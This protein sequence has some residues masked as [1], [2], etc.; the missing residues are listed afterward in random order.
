MSDAHDISVQ[1]QIPPM[2]VNKT[3]E[4]LVIELGLGRADELGFNNIAVLIDDECNLG[5]TGNS[6][7]GGQSGA[8]TKGK[9]RGSKKLK[10]GQQHGKSGIRQTPRIGGCQ[11]LL[12]NCSIDPPPGE[13][14]KGP[15]LGSVEYL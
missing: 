10:S 1:A 4:T 6:G 2:I 15:H 12:M 13:V 5:L 7:T 14:A 9:G 3:S 8:D 11:A